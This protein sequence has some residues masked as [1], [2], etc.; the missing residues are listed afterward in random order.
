MRGT[1][2]EAPTLVLGATGAQGGAVAR[3]LRADGRPVRAL[4][5]DP[6]STATL[7]AMG[8]DIAVGT[9]E[10]IP[11]LDRAVAGCRAVFSVQL[12]PSPLDPDRERRQAAALIAAARR[13]SVTHLVHSSVSNTGDF[14]HMAGWDEG[15]WE[16]N[17]WQSKADVEAM[18]R[19]AGFISHTL[20]RPAFMME[21]FATPKAASMFPDLRQGRILTAVEPDTRIALI[22]AD[23][24]GATAAAAVADPARFGD[25]PI[26]LAGD[27]RTLPEVAAALGAAMDMAVTAETLDYDRLVARGQHDGWVQMQI[28]LNIVGYPA[29]PAQMTALGLRPTRF[30]DWIASNISGILIDPA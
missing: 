28:W 20:L 13:N 12:A 30:E 25:V 4:V 22:A 26:E 23:D 11:A 10:D 5:R 3:A 9:F 2:D 7:A 24:I 8:C 29:R 19:E 1:A 17:Y 16:R 6:A 27:H 18:V 15:R 14:D 21:N